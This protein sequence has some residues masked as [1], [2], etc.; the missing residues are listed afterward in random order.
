MNNFAIAISIALQYGVPLEEFVDAFT[1][2]RFEPAGIVIG[3]DSIKNAT[4]VLDY[5]F[6]ELAVSYLGRNDLA[7]V[8][9]HHDEDLG[10]GVAEGQRSQT[11]SRTTSIGYVRGNVHRIGVVRGSAAPKML[12][13]HDEIEHHHHDHDDEVQLT[14]DLSEIASSVEASIAEVA[15]EAGNPVGIQVA[16]IETR[17][18]AGTRDIHARRAEAKMKGYEGDACGTCGNFTLVRNGTCMK[19]NTCGST[20]GCS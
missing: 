15:N 9:P 1:F 5:I 19:C 18:N 7:H 8:P 12:E 3:N 11:V 4:S 17:L 6:R 20:S 16:T 2:T 10:G 13:M 14:V